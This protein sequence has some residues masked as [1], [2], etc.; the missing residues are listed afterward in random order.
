[1]PTYE[2][3]CGKC[4]HRFE[5]FQNFTDAPLKRCP[6]C[7]GGVRRVIHGGAGLVFKG[8]GFYCT[9]YRGG[10]S[11]K[12]GASEKCAAGKESSGGKDSGRA[13]SSSADD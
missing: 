5:R 8:S 9:D 7:R 10:G 3:A 13:D 1:M 6:K 4:G 12:A 2:Y 11:K